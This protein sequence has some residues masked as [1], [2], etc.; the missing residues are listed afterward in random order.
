[1]ENGDGARKLIRFGCYT[2]DRERASLSAN[3]EA[4]ALR[5]KAFDVLLFLLDHTGRVVSKDELG[6]AVWPGVAVSD[7]S[8]AKAVSEVRL[9]LGAEGPQIIKTVP[10]RGYVFELPITGIA[11]QCGPPLRLEHGAARGIRVDAGRYPYL[12]SWHAP[13]LIAAVLCIAVLA[14][15]IL[16]ASAG[17]ARRSADGHPSIAVLPFANEGSPQRDYLS[18]GLAEDLTTSLGKFSDLYVIGYGSAS[19]YKGTA[20]VPEIGAKLGASYLVDGTVRRDG[21]KLRITAGLIDAITGRQLWADSYDCMLTDIFA[22]QDKVVRNIV[23]RVLARVTRLELERARSKPAGSW[24]AY[25]YV[26]QGKALIDHRRGEDRG[27][28]AGAA[29]ELFNKAVGIDPRYAPAVEGLAASYSVAWL[30]P[31]R[32]EPF[33][34]EFQRTETMNRASELAHRAVELDPFLARAHATLAWILH[35]QYRRDD[36]LAEFE[37]ARESNSNLVDGRYGLMLAHDGRAD[38]GIAYLMRIMRREPIP[39][40]INWSYLG[41]AYFLA[42]RYEDARRALKAGIES[43][44]DYRPLYLWLA[45]AAAQAGDEAEARH[46]ASAALALNPEFALDR[47]LHH[48]RLARA[49]D[50][51]RL[52]AGM[53]KAGLPR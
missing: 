49:E 20:A 46:A 39:P 11:A 51:E 27:A 5:P 43:L 13:A 9:A 47:W 31:T 24:Q 6:D 26:L 4:V 41:N 45:A 38:E 36:A 44:P 50:A 12:R 14:G 21:E 29:R 23:G 15:V 28:M 19:A 42:G 48:I 7:E 10:R 34:R 33:H 2:V 18:D 30:E 22:V 37:R 17:K 32:Y 3:G 40:P 52:A 16:T 53:R 1:M 25:D 8:L 35:W